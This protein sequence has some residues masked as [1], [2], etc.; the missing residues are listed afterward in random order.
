MDVVEGV[1][2]S[3]SSKRLIGE[4]AVRRRVT[5][6]DKRREVD[7]HA[8][9]VG[10]NAPTTV[11]LEMCPKAIERDSKT[12]YVQSMPDKDALSIERDNGGTP[13]KNRK[14]GVVAHSNL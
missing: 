2:R 11:L 4:S 14:V 8:S 6:E 12:R 7:E 13:S 9:V 1:E 3:R 10:T 5:L